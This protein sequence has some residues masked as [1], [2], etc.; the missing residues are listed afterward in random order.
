MKLTYQVLLSTFFLGIFIFSVLF[1]VLAH[2]VGASPGQFYLEDLA[3]G[4]TVQKEITVTRT[5]PTEDAFFTVELSGDDARYAELPTKNF[6]IP[7]GKK[8]TPYTFYIKPNGAQNG[9]HQFKI[10]F[11]EQSAPTGKNDGARVTVQ[12]GIMVVVT[13]NITDRQVKNMQLQMVS[14]PDTEAG[15]PLVVSFIAENGGNVDIRPTKIVGTFKD[16]SDH[17]NVVEQV[18]PEDQIDVIPPFERKNL[19]AKFPNSL[20]LGDYV[21]TV[22]FYLDENVVYETANM[23]FTVHPQ[24]TLAQEAVFKSLD[25]SQTTVKPNELVKISAVIQN[26]GSVGIEP[27]FFV[28]LKKDGQLFD[29]L[30]A[31]KKLIYKGQEGSYFVTFRPDQ[32]GEYTGDVYFEYGNKQT[33]HK[34]VTIQVI[35]KQPGASS[36]P[37]NV[38]MGG[39][40]LLV[41]IAAGWW[42]IKKFFL[43]QSI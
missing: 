20:P 24:G 34:Q 36:L 42:I 13:F 12:S 21:A 9:E 33:D 28:E 40:L 27:S 17:T 26:T 39:G 31:D 37:K 14:V 22:K 16:V 1:P 2:A 23:Y 19:T 3:N 29:L 4:I 25:V 8:S 43:S 10:L 5:D 15:L 32:V 38:A 35:N 11:K 6:V 7:A 41:I 18:I 30:R